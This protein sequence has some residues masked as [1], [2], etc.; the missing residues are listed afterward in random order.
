M[1]L[2]PTV[3]STG[4]WFMLDLLRYNT[5]CAGVVM[6]PMQE[7]AEEW[8]KENVV[9]HCHMGLNSLLGQ[10]DAAAFWSFEDIV[11]WL[12]R[13]RTIVPLRDPLLALLTAHQRG[14]TEE[15][16]GI[17]KARVLNGFAVLGGLWKQYNIHTLPVDLCAG[18]T[19]LERYEHLRDAMRFLGWPLQPYLAMTSMLWPVI[20]T[21]GKFTNK[22]LYG[23]RQI[24]RIQ[25]TLSQDFEALQR[26]EDAVRPMLES[27]GY[28][29][30]M[31]WT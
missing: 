18:M 29:N 24:E 4:T 12:A 13:N 5:A 19:E 10:R 17:L 31:W 7:K 27:A 28:E 23:T 8:S 9:V 15:E 22:T 30:L 26:T 3:Q 6:A 16:R 20:N 11:Y 14:R 21:T 25:N 2:V 1:I